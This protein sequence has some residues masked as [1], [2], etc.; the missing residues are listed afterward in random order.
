MTEHQ[1]TRTVDDYCAA[2]NAADEIQ[3]RALLLPVLAEGATY[4]DPT[5]HAVGLAQL[6]AHIAGVAAR[7]P[8]AILTRTSAVDAH[9]AVARFTWQVTQTDGAV[10]REGI[11][12]VEFAADGHLT[13]V[14]GFFGPPPPVKN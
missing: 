5:V 12:L 2:W 6:L 9:H 1:F 3:R 13:K 8:G 11:D 4:T 10:L 7:R 14:V